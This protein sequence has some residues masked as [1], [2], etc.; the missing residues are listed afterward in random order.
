MAGFYASNTMT[1]EGL[2]KGEMPDLVMIFIGGILSAYLVT[3]V[4]KRIGNDFF[5]EGLKSIYYTIYLL[6]SFNF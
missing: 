1:Y 2:S 3:Y 4:L 6:V 5:L